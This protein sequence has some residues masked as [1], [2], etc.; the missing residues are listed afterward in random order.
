MDRIYFTEQKSGYGTMFLAVSDKGLVKIAFG[1]DTRFDFFSWLEKHFPGCIF[2]KNDKKTGKY[3]K[4]IQAFIDGR[5]KSINLPVDLRTGGFQ[6]KV[7]MELQK[8]PYGE[9]VTY[10]ELAARAGNPRACRAAG[11]ACKKNPLPFVIPCH[12]AIAAGRRLGGY[13]GGEKLKRRLL[14]NEGITG[15]KD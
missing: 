14:E 11:S 5:A 8:V 6:G 12:R 3:A 2:E 7:L 9:V 4:K 10:G 1:R 15:L 13:G